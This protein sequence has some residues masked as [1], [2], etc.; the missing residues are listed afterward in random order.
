[1]PHNIFLDMNLALVLPLILLLLPTAHCQ[2]NQFTFPMPRKVGDVAISFQV[3]NTYNIEWA[4]TATSY[5]VS[6][7]SEDR[8]PYSQTFGINNP[9]WYS[10]LMISLPYW[11]HRLSDST[12][13]IA[14]TDLK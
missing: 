3:G 14:Q 2:A 1:M 9:G 6:V 7:A 4:T 10:S 8:G 11:L 5:F 12:L 13:C